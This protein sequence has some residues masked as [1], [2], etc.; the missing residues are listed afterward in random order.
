MDE[1]IKTIEVTLSRVI[2]A[3]GE[4]FFRFYAPEGFNSIEVL[5]L[6]SAGQAFVYRRM[7][8]EGT[9]NE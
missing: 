3:N 7:Q 9:P 5:G 1:P 4:M 2:N 8:W 6:L